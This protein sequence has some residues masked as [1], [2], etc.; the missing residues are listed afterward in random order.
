MA[1]GAYVLELPKGGYMKRTLATTIVAA[2]A[3]AAC[4]GSASTNT[5]TAKQ[6]VQSKP[7]AAT[8]KKKTATHKKKAT[9][10]K[11]A[12][13][14][15]SVSASK[16]APTTNSSA[17]PAPTPTTSAAPAPTTTATPPPPTTTQAPPPPTHTSHHHKNTCPPTCG[18]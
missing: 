6:A 18:Y 14:H 17:T 12:A 7:T 2:I 8:T 10:H 5:H 11:K 3:L 15:K 9:P 4:G 13:V 16:P 1:G